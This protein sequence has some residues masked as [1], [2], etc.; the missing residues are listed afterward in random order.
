[1]WGSFSQNFPLALKNHQLAFNIYSLPIVV[2][3]N[4]LDVGTYQQHISTIYHQQVIITMDTK[5]T[6]CIYNFLF[7]TDYNPWVYQQQVN[8]VQLYKSISSICKTQLTPSAST[9]MRQQSSTDINLSIG[10][11][12]IGSEAHVCTRPTSSAVYVYTCPSNT[13]ACVYAPK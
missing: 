8:T 7:I 9:E 10:T 5:N 12:P 13:T 6:G 2:I 4:Q 11:R 3:Y 1:M